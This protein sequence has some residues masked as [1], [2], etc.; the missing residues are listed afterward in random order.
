MTVIWSAEAQA[1]LVAIHEHVAQD[2]PREADALIKRLVDRVMQLETVPNSGRRVPEYPDNDL[3]ELLSRPYRIIYRQRDE[4]VEVV[5]VMHYRQ[6][7]P[8]NPQSLI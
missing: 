3:R 5:T 2:A 8:F 7:L 4:H 6:Q 1:Q